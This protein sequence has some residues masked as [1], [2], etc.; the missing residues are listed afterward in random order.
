MANSIEVIDRMSAETNVDSDWHI[1]IQPRR[2]VV[3]QQCR[4][5]HSGVGELDHLLAQLAHLAKFLL[6]FVLDQPCASD[7]EIAGALMCAHSGPRQRIA[8]HGRPPVAPLC[9]ARVA[10]PSTSKG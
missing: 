6:A 10:S 1:P 3:P 9:T 4:Q 7:Q 2:G 8:Q 5:A